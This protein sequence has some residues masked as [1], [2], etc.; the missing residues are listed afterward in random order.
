MNGGDEGGQL[1]YAAV[2]DGAFTPSNPALV[3]RLIGAP[4]LPKN[5]W[6]KVSI[7][8]PSTLKTIYGFILSAAPGLSQSRVYFDDIHLV[9]PFVLSFVSI[10]NVALL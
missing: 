2:I 9:R 5:L 6:S 4:V 7:P 8:I 3:H 1:V 10:I